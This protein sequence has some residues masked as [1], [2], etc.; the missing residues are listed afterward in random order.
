[1]FEWVEGRQ[2]SGYYKMK[3]FI[4]KWLRMDCYLLKFDKGV[5]VPWHV[6]PAKTGK[7]F[8]LNIT[9]YGCASVLTEHKPQI[10]SKRLMLFRPDINRHMMERAEAPIYMLS[11]GKVFGNVS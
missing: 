6:D 9:L 5:K 7:H 8:R 4:C 10:N 11:I 3:L 1:M 2:N